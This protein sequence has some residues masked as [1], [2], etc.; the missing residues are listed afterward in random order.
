MI[1][2]ARR[3]QLIRSS[4]SRE[5]KAEPGLTDKQPKGVCWRGRDSLE[6][7]AS[8][9]WRREGAGCSGR[10]GP[11]AFRGASKASEAQEESEAELIG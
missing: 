7:P 9:G 5:D 11:E 4:R 3:R 8:R 1:S 2:V 6:E 10:T